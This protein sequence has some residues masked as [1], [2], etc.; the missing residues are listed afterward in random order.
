MMARPVVRWLLAQT[1]FGQRIILHAI[2][3]IRTPK[4]RSPA[5]ALD[6]LRHLVLAMVLLVLGMVVA[7]T[8]AEAHVLHAPAVTAELAGKA[9]GTKSETGGEAEACE[10]ICC[11]PAACASALPPVAALSPGRILLPV[12]HGLPADESAEAHPQTAPIRPPR[13]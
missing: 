2:T 7:P 8:E 4:R 10:A 6:A 1:L 3:T 13:H 12:R 11:S 9:T 5:R